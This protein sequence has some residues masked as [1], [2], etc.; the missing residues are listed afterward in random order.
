MTF[1]PT[2]RASRATAPVPTGTST[3]A[4]SGKP[5]AEFQLAWTRDLTK[6]EGAKP[7]DTFSAQF[8]F[9]FSHVLSGAN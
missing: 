6:K 1:A 3:A 2:T 8:R 7:T 4:L 5:G 9:E